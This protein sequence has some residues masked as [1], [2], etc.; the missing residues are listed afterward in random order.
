MLATYAAE[1]GFT[2]AL[3]ISWLS[4]SSAGRIGHPYSMG[5]PAAWARAALAGEDTARAS[6]RAAPHSRATADPAT[7][8]SSVRGDR[9]GTERLIANTLAL[10]AAGKGRSWTKQR[11]R[12]AQ[13]ESRGQPRSGRLVAVQH[14]RA[15]LYQQRRTAVPAVGCAAAV[16][17]AAGAAL[18]VNAG[19]S[20]GEQSLYLAQLR[21]HLLQL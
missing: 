5:E 1:L 7:P 11:A 21:V 2:G 6:T 18:P 12:S 9:A 20:S 14:G 15:R 3:A 19:L 10:A 17:R 8:T 13:A 4:G 16:Y